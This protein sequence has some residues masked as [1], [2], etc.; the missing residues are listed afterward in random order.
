VA[1]TWGDS[2]WGC[3]THA[4]DALVQVPSVFLASEAPIGLNAYRERQSRA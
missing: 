3:W 1:D 2:A 4:E